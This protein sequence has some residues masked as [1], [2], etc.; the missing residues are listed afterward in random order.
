MKKTIVFTVFVLI[1]TIGKAQTRY[2]VFN[3]GSLEKE[4][5][6]IAIALVKDELGEPIEQKDKFVLWKKKEEDYRYTIKIKLKGYKMVYKGSNLLIRD[7]LKELGEKFIPL[8]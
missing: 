2:S 3:F 1:A 8:E 5:R 6:D 4:K 7:K